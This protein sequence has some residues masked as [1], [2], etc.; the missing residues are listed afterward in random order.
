MLPNSWSFHRIP[1]FLGSPSL[2]TPHTDGAP[3]HGF[4]SPQR[5]P[6]LLLGCFFPLR[7]KQT[8]SSSQSRAA[9]VTSNRPSMSCSRFADLC[10]QLVPLL[11][12]LITV[13]TQP[14]PQAP[15]HPVSSSNQLPTVLGPHRHSHPGTCATRAAGSGASAGTPRI[16]N[17]LLN[18]M[19]GLEQQERMSWHSRRIRGLPWV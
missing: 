4:S 10:F 2:S 11:S 19:G 5:C 14:R 6:A 16:I 15:V 13:T 17:I 1:E 18:N 7:L 9:S 3:G 12:Q 8:F